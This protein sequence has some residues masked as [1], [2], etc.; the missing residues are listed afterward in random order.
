LCNWGITLKQSSAVHIAA[1]YSADVILP[2]SRSKY[3]LLVINL[4]S[5]P[6]RQLVNS[7]TAQ[8]LERHMPFMRPY[9]FAILFISLTPQVFSQTEMD[10]RC[11]QR[12]KEFSADLHFPKFIGQV[13]VSKDTIKFDSSFIAIQATDP[14]IKK[15]FEIGLV[16]PDLIYGASTRSDKFE[17]KNIFSADTLSIS[18]VK[19]LHFPN[20]R[21]ETKCFSFLLWHK[22]MANPSLYIFELT[23]ETATSKT[24]MT[25]FIEK[26]KVTAFGFCSILI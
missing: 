13:N 11:M 22:M 18:N 24:T 1:L 2:G 9:I 20:Q 17:F 5:V 10:T 21:A 6:G 4:A 15:I 25:T 8:S 7:I 16:F 23:N 12:I 19:E 3:R 26:A 14:E